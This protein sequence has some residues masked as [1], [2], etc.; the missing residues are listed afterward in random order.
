MPGTR[1]FWALT[2]TVLTMGCENVVT[3]SG[4]PEFS[5]EGAPPLQ[6]TAEV[7]QSVVVRAPYIINTTYVSDW[8]VATGGPG[9]DGF[10]VR[11]TCV[12]PGTATYR[13]GTNFNTYTGT[14]TCECP[15]KC[16]TSISPAGALESQEPVLPRRP[17][18]DEEEDPCHDQGAVAE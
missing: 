17:M 3:E 10:S 4:P 11:I 8:Q 6:I 12:G 16:A 13:V 2:F 7:G 5:P 9:D 14:I 1:V 15:C 18:S